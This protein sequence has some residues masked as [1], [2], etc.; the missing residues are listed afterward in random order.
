MT[1]GHEALLL[2]LR[3]AIGALAA[4]LIVTGQ[5]IDAIF[6]VA[7]RAVI[8]GLPRTIDR[9]ERAFAGVHVVRPHAAIIGHADRMRCRAVDIEDH[10]F[11]GFALGL[12]LIPSAVLAATLAALPAAALLALLALL[13]LILL[14]LHRHRSHAGRMPHFEIGVRARETGVSALA[15]LTQVIVVDFAQ[16]GA[17]IARSHHPERGVVERV[18]HLGTP[19]RLRNIA[20]RVGGSV[21][22]L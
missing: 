7:A 12:F 6:L 21:Y 20:R 1:D 17:T 10:R 16:G 2:L 9:I 5:H 8:N 19:G 3:R 14:L 4:A 11:G 13:L 18:A 15:F 22:K